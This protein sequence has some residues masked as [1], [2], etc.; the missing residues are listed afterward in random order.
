[1]KWPRVQ[2][3]SPRRSA[4]DEGED[5]GGIQAL[6]GGAATRSVAVQRRRSQS[7][8]RLA[9]ARPSGPFPSSPAETYRGHYRTRTKPAKPLADGPVHATSKRSVN[10]GQ[11]GRGNGG[12]GPPTRPPDVEPRGLLG[13]KARQD[14]YLKRSRGDAVLD[15]HG[16]RQ[17][18]CRSSRFASG[19][20]F[21]QMENLLSFQCRPNRKFVGMASNRGKFPGGRGSQ[22]LE[23][24]IQAG[25]GSTHP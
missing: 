9:R 13:G 25:D 14:R 12:S 16:L 17:R 22:G 6:D 10:K 20:P 1:M 2:G 21:G 23:S 3:A 19:A 15:V 18:K 24:M 5:G 4:I 8:S 7:P 11:S